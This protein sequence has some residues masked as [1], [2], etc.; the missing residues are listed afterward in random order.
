MRAF[1]MLR[2]LGFPVVFDVTHSLQLPGAGDGVTAGLAQFIEPLASA[3]VA[4]GVDGVFLEVHEDP[5]ARRATRR[6]P[7]ASIALEP[8]CD[9]LRAHRR[10]RQGPTG[11]IAAVTVTT[12]TDVDLAR[13]RARDRGRRH[14]RPRRPPRRRASSAPSTLLQDCRGRVIVTGMGKS[15]IICRKI[16][17]TLVEHRHARVLPAPRRGHPRRSRRH[18]GRRRGGR[19]VVQRRDRG[20][21]AAARDHPPDRRAAHRHHRRPGV[22]ARA[23]GRRRARLPASTEEACP[24]NLAPDGQ[25]DRRARARRRAG[26]DAARRARASARRTSPTSIRAASS[27]S[28]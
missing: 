9:R 24:M 10:H 12:L 14:P 2:A 20:T 4:A 18:P 17:A 3:G 26:D 22:D 1:P 13:A 6:T 27:A 25:H 8:C 7:C 19:A 11:G 5:P 16:A 23:G 15:G 21:A 28:A